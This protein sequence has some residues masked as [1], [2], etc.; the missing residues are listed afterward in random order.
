MRIAVLGHYSSGSSGISQILSRL[1]VDMGG[2]HWWEVDDVNSDQNHWEPYSMAQQLGD[3]WSEPYMRLR[4]DRNELVDYLKKWIENREANAPADVTD[5]GAKHP[6]FSM[7]CQVLKEAWG[8]ETC[9]IWSYRDLDE[10]K[11]KFLGRFP[12]FRGYESAAQDELWNCLQYFADKNQ[13]TQIVWDDVKSNPER[14]VRHLASLL[15][16]PPCEQQIKSAIA[17]IKL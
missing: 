11:R 12:K 10:S 4:V 5:F 16:K 2:P 15:S 13:V 3:W 8:E 1:G 17:C 6:T 7:S 9:F 14:T